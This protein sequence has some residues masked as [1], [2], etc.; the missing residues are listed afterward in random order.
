MPFSLFSLENSIGSLVVAGA[1]V[2]MCA[3]ATLVTPRCPSLFS[4]VDVENGP[5]RDSVGRLS[6]VCWST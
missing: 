5:N 6:A 1:D 3:G 2:N 4:G